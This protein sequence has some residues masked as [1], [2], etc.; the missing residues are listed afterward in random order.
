VFDVEKQDDD[1]AA[2]QELI[3]HGAEH[4]FISG[5][6]QRLKLRD[7]VFLRGK[8]DLRRRP[9]GNLRPDVQ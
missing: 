3:D 4:I 1:T 7:T 9:G 6:N 8:E 2:L 5:V